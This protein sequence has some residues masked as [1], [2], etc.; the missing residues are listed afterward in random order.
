MEIC[1]VCFWFPCREFSVVNLSEASNDQ[2][3]FVNNDRSP[4]LAGSGHAPACVF[5]VM[6]DSPRLSRPACAGFPHLRSPVECS[7]PPGAV[8][9]RRRTRS[10]FAREPPVRLDALSLRLTQRFASTALCRCPVSSWKAQSASLVAKLRRP[11]MAEALH[12]HAFSDATPRLVDFL[13]LPSL[14]RR[15]IAASSSIHLQIS[16]LSIRFNFRI[17]SLSCW[18]SIALPRFIVIIIIT[19]RDN[20]QLLLY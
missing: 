16:F 1:F 12:V 6:A 3:V 4:P 8:W 2:A 17:S 14:K 20:A 19:I 11:L 5:K 10:V 15:P 7:T 18:I 9:L 13:A